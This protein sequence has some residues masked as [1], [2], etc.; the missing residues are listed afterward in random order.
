[1][2]KMRV[3]RKAETLPSLQA[4]GRTSAVE[5]LAPARVP[6]FPAAHWDGYAAISE[7]VEAASRSDPVALMLVGEAGPG[8]RP[9]LAIRNGEAVRVATGAPLPTGADTVI[10]VEAAEANPDRV[11]ATQPSPPGNHV[12]RAGEDVEKGEPVLARGQTVRAQDVGFLISLGLSKVRVWKKPIVGV[13]A[14]GSELVEAGKP[15][16]GKVLNSHTPVFTNLLERTGCAPLDFG[17]AR[18]D[19][20]EILGKL[21]R[22]LARSDL[23]LT[24]GGT[25]AGRRDLVVPA[26]EGIHP[27]LLIHG[28]AMDRGRV[29]GIA[30]A[31][32]KPIIMMPGPVQGAANAFFVLA[33]PIIK[34][35]SGAAGRELEIRCRFSGT[36]EARSQYASFRK[37]IYIRFE[38]RVARPIEAETE[39]MKVLARAN[40]YLVVPENVTRIEDGDEVDVRLIPGFSFS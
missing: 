34:V 24:L 38:G 15:R 3:K 6:P 5:V 2:A 25:S 17:I 30:V 22:A 11:F 4:Y 9:R 7:D 1:M 10:P 32:G 33:V 13:L 37:V 29:T 8:A 35:L 26:V 19:R 14:T 23:V 40:A 31:R 16:S 18:D 28:I 12:Y 21:K 36:W 20:S 27:Q 39:S